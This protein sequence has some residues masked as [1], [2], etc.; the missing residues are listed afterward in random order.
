VTLLALVL[1]IIAPDMGLM[2][3][4][5]TPA[6][7]QS[8]YHSDLTTPTANDY[9][10]WDV[11]QGCSFY[12]T[13][14]DANGAN[15]AGDSSGDA[16]CAFKPSSVGAD[17]SQGFSLDLT[18]APAAN[19]SSF[20]ESVLALGDL[21]SATSSG[22]WFAVGQD[23]KFIICDAICRAGQG[24]YIQGASSAWHEDAFVANSFA[25]RVSANHNDETFYINGQQV[26]EVSLDLGAQP[27]LAVG[28][29]GGS[30][31]IFTAVRLSTGS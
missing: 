2:A 22:L 29:P 5:L 6:G 8:A 7:W 25:A 3:G 31:T 4:G 19:V 28:A 9:R 18:L 12:S 23:G 15:G 17:I 14:L 13:G 21:S 26:A 10:A 20:Q 11:S 24:V 1:A 30:E 16:I 27:A